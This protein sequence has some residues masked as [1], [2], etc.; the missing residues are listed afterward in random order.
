MVRAKT[1]G[2][3]AK[4]SERDVIA[5]GARI[6]LAE[7]TIQKVATELDVTP[8]AI[9]RHVAD[10]RDLERLVGED[11]LSRFNPGYE[12]AVSA[13]A[14]L[15]TFANELRDFARAHPGVARYVRHLFPRSPAGIHVVEQQVAALA[16]HGYHPGTALA[17][18]SAVADITLALVVANEV[19]PAMVDESA[20]SAPDAANATR[21]LDESGLLGEP[22]P[23]LVAPSRSDVDAALVGHLI[24]GMLH[25]LPPDA[26]LS[27]AQAQQRLLSAMRS[28]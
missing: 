3:V 4:I 5:A 7:L 12:S 22:A 10:R 6:G 18:G 25:A 14:F 27:P 9:Y 23:G 1:G 21:M 17:L 19:N 2:R 15:L 8:A 28:K 24:D 16:A 13:R 11:L 26:H 20:A